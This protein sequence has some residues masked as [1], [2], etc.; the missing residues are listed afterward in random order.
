MT[1]TVNLLLEQM[2]LSLKKVAMSVGDPGEELHCTWRDGGWYYIT[3]YG[4]EVCR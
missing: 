3:Y 2:N 1:Q 4:Y